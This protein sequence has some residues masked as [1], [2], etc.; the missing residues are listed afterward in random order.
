MIQKILFEIILISQEM[1]PATSDLIGNREGNN[2]ELAYSNTGQRFRISSG[3]TN[4]TLIASLA[5]A[6]PIP[7]P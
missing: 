5:S 6:L 7:F 1:K 2:A 3:V 4:N